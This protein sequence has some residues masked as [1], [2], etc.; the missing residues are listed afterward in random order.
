MKIYNRKC[1]GNRARLCDFPS[2]FPRK[3]LS[4]GNL[5]T[6]DLL[7]PTWGP[8]KWAD[9]AA[10]YHTLGLLSNPMLN[11]KY[12]V[13]VETKHNTL[14]AMKPV[15]NCWTEFGQFSSSTWSVSDDSPE[16]ILSERFSNVCLFNK[17]LKF[18]STRSNLYIQT[19]LSASRN[20]VTGHFTTTKKFK[21]NCLLSARHLN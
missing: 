12:Q 2:I 13:L 17:L 3:S 10:A 4:E 7:K 21:S 15:K 8:P 5:G 11:E 18:A 9:P 19:S 6:R 20:R 1:A 16:Q 14:W